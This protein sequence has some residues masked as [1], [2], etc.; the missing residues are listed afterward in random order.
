[1][2]PPTW[3]I[4]NLKIEHIHSEA[5]KYVTVS[6]GICDNATLSTPNEIIT[7]SNTALQ[8]AKT[9]GRN[10]LICLHHNEEPNPS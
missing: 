2:L 1:M 8:Q 3:M 4:E 5:G 10:R 7:D 9:E 6:I